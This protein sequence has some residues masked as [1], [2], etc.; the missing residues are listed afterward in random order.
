MSRAQADI[1]AASDAL[2]IFAAARDAGDATAL[3]I[4]EQSLSFAQLARHVAV[5]LAELD[6]RGTTLY[7]LIGSNTLETLVTLY[8]LLETRTAALLLHP[9]HTESE[10][11]AVLDAARDAGGSSDPDVAAVIYTSGTS[12]APRGVVLTRS[13]LRSSAEASAANLGWED[14]DCWLLA[15]PLARVGGLS[16]VTR[17]LA[18]RR[19]VALAPAFDARLLPDWIAQQRVTLIS[20]VPTMLAKCLAEH[21]GWTPP[22]HLRAILLGGAAASPRLLAQA[23]QRGLPIVITYG[24]TETC[25]QV[26][27]TPYLRRYAAAS[28]GAGQALEG[29]QLRVAGGR[30]E[31][32]GAMLMSGYLGEP[33]L[34]RDAWFDTGDLGEIDDQGWLHVHARRTDLIVSG[35]ENIYPAEVERVLEIC[36]GVVAAGVFGVADEIWGQTIAAALVVAADAPPDQAIIDHMVAHLAAYKRPRQVCVVPALPHTGAGKLDRQALRDMTAALRPLRSAGSTV[37]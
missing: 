9:R 26:V 20:L 31:V 25:S 29:V 37:D 23:A 21:P 35:G 7:P 8:A 28:C 6:L 18:A 14:N 24:C 15:M 19:A 13:A 17:C 12:G 10:R 32:R 16:I 1:G 36:A 27:T 33:A 4:G 30:I 22:S 34:E 11:G 3:R 2:S 5:R